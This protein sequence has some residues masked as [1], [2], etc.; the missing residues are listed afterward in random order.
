MITI[1]L[2]GLDQ[3]VAGHYCKT[4]TENLAQLFEIE[5]DEIS[6]YAPNSMIIHKGIEQTS[7]NTEVIVHLP[8]KYAV[9]EKKVADYLIK[10]LKD[11]TINLNITF[12]YFE[13]SSHYQY[14]NEDYPRFIKADNIID[15]DDPYA[16]EDAEE[17][18]GPIP[19]PYLG[20]VFEGKQDELDA[21]Y[22]AD[23]EYLSDKDK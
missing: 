18:D 7:W 2:L 14:I 15:A 11:I 1:S 12:E 22:S 17:Y 16:E 13:E 10:T 3:Y 9:L 8:T 20:N 23:E 5:E 6:F 4:H 19:E 21:K